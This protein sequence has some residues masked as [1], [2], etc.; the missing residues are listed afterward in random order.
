[1]VYTYKIALLYVNVGEP[2]Q[3]PDNYLLNLQH[4]LDIPMYVLLPSLVFLI[5][6]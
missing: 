2:E 6:S 3:P 1:M 5:P 4:I